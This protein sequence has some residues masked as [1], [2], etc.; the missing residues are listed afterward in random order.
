MD[1]RFKV[2]LLG[3]AAVGKTSLLLRYI[4]NQFAESYKMT[5]GVDFLSK[6][7]NINDNRV[8]LTIWDV[9]GQK[10]F[11]FMRKSF[12]GGSSGALLIFDLTRENTFQYLTRRWYPEMTKFIGNE[13]PFV[14]IGNKLDLVKDIG[15]VINESE[16][17]EFAQSK[18]SIY[19]ETSAKTGVNVEIAFE[20]LAERMVSKTGLNS[21]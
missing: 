21:D 16:A 20:E 5:I 2:I 10:R 7:L 11:S 8:N 1:Y 14:L 3:E 17:Q 13:V 9:A 12:Y 15:S 6:K 18:N 19:I 4:R